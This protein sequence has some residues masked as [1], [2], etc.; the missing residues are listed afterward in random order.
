MAAAAV[1]LAAPAPASAADTA[2]P[3]KDLREIRALL[4]RFVP[5]AVA[6]KDPASVFRLAAPSMREGV[7]RAQWDSGMLPVVPYPVRPSGFGIRPL[8]VKPGDIVFDLMLHPRAGSDVGPIVFTTEVRR[9]GGRWLMAS[10]APTAQ[11]SPVG[12]A[13]S[14]T[15]EPDLAPH[16]GNPGNARLPETWIL[17]PIAVVGLPLAL[18]P[19]ALAVVWYRGRRQ[20]AAPDARASIP[21]R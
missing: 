1:L 5:A 17:V 11:F 19:L 18:T 3:P 16:A 4:D 14:I 15:A 9:I 13:P 6:R 8:S 20:R 21:W 2:I 7:T 10:M 12:S